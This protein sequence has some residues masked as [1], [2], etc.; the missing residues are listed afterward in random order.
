MHLDATLFAQL[1]V[2]LLLAMR[3]L[4]NNRIYG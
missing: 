2:F 3:R 4:H 1:I